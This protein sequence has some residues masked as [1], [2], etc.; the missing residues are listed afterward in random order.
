[1]PITLIQFVIIQLIKIKTI[2]RETRPACISPLLNFINQ[3]HLNRHARNMKSIIHATLISTFC[4][5]V[6][7]TIPATFPLKSNYETEFSFE[8]STKISFGIA[9]IQQKYSYNVF[10]GKGP[11]SNQLV[12]TLKNPTVDDR[13]SKPKPIDLK[14]LQTPFLINVNRDGEWIS[15]ATTPGESKIS[16]EQ[17]EN[18]ATILTNNETEYVELKNNLKAKPQGDPVWSVDDTPLG[19]CTSQNLLETSE[20][21]ETVHT[22]AS[23]SN[24]TGSPK[25]GLLDNFGI[26]ISQDSEFG[27]SMTTDKAT[28][29]FN[30]AELV[31]VMRVLTLPPA[32]VRVHQ[33]LDFVGYREAAESEFDLAQLTEIHTLEELE[34]I[35]S[36]NLF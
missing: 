33:Q 31:I 25:G 16:L 29:K 34:K 20:L 28:G 17:K 11:E 24:C 18:I 14:N 2:N 6:T 3:S 26:D 35:S 30:K 13:L 23:R 32:D 22:K 21:S 10:V 5:I 1:M 19:D 36:N 7:A 12:V 27:F 8:S 9:Q 4:V 15:I